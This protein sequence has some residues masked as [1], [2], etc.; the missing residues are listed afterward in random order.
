MSKRYEIDLDKYSLQ[1]F[2]RSLQSREMIPSRVSLKD[3][4]DGRFRILEGRG[5][6]NL[7]ELVDALK[8]KQKIERFSQETGLSTQYL[9]LLNREAKSYLSRPIR[10]DKLPGMRTEYL[11][12]LEDEGLRNTKQLFLDAQQYIHRIAGFPELQ[13]HRK[14]RGEPSHGS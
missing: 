3:D 4:L 14:N 5:I 10:L 11:D 1:K 9:T 8:T 12:R 7:G 13:H 6:A 2:K